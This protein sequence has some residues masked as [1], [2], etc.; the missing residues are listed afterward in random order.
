MIVVYLHRI[1]QSMLYPS[2][3]IFLWCSGMYH[4]CR[5]FESEHG[6]RLWVGE[7]QPNARMLLLR[8]PSNPERSRLSLLT[9]FIKLESFFKERPNPKFATDTSTSCRDDQST[10]RRKTRPRSSSWSSWNPTRHA[11][12]ASATSTLDGHPG[13]SASL[14]ASAALAFTALWAFTSLASNRSI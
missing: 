5:M 6:N 12:T 14:S 8:Q 10:A 1:F 3:L 11:L 2:R 7:P 9:A 13:T 4:T